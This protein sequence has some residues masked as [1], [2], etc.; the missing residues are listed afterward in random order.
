MGL[1]NTKLRGELVNL[2]P[3]IRIYNGASK[4][5]ASVCNMA[6]HRF[7]FFGVCLSDA[8]VFRILNNIE[9]FIIGSPQFI[10]FPRD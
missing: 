2:E 8:I 9:G 5:M 1:E 6:K 3:I 10:E 4:A 7:K